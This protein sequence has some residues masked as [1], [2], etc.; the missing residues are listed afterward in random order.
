V[1]RGELWTVSGGPGAA[2]KPRPALIV[3]SE[4]YPDTHSITVCPVTSTE[5]VTAV[6]RQDVEPD[7]GNGLRRS[8]RIMIDK[9]TTLPRSRLGRRVGELSSEDMARVDRALL[10]F[11]GLAG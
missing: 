6:M 3:Q 5:L 2:G 11:L 7:A 1:K 4:T 9:V 10:V 8:S